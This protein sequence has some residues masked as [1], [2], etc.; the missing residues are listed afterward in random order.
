MNSTKQNFDETRFNVERVKVPPQKT[1]RVAKIGEKKFEERLL[2]KWNRP[3]SASRREQME[4]RSG[5]TALGRNCVGDSGAASRQ[6]GQI[7]K[8]EII[9]VSQTVASRCFMA[10]ATGRA[11][12]ERSR[13]NRNGGW[14]RQKGG[15]VRAGSSIVSR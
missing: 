2:C 12:L 11:P 15:E 5:R 9:K 1:G 13:R 14:R 3:R 6:A 10:G 8:L 4:K 7:I